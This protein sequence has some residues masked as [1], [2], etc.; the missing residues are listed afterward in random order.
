M[1]GFS[2]RALNAL[3][4]AGIRTLGELWDKTEGPDGHPLIWIRGLGAITAQEIEKKTA[5]F[6]HE[7][8]KTNG[9]AKS[10]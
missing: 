6:W 4:N 3:E 2:N 9:H 1:G 7:W 5:Q 10:N 8:S